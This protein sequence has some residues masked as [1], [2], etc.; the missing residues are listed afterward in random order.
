MIR[1][2]TSLLSA[3]TFLNRFTPFLLVNLTRIRELHHLKSTFSSLLSDFQYVLQLS[4]TKEML[5]IFTTSS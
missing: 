3:I 4:T 1:L 5:A 2:V